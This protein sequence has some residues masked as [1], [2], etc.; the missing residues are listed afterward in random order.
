M[1]DYKAKE[2]EHYNSRYTIYNGSAITENDSDLVNKNAINHFYQ[3]VIDIQSVLGSGRI[4]DYG[5]G[6]G[7]KSTSVLHPEWTL[8]GID[9]SEESIAIAQRKYA[10]DINVSFSVMDCENTTFPDNTF[11]LIFDY[12]SFSSIDIKKAIKEITRILKPNGTLI[13]IETLGHNPIL[14]FKR[15]ISVFTGRRT[16]WASTHIMRIQNWQYIQKYF[17]ISK[18]SH[19]NI[20]AIYISPFL[21]IMPKHTREV[22]LK[23]IWS[24]DKALLKNKNLSKY[25]F[26]SVACLQ[27]LK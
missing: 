20:L 5:C 3:Y 9:I 18:I 26:K 13:A 8:D 21:G 14:N 11:D 27:V 1:T 10:Q 24:I 25:A 16:R 2:R 17:R 19:F 7:D 6:I 15:R 23:R 12:G 4:L 22:M